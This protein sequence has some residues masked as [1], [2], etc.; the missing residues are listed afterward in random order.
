MS[1]NKIRIEKY[2]GASAIGSYGDRKDELCSVNSTPG[3]GFLA[4]VCKDWEKAHS[5]VPAIHS[6]IVR[7]GVVLDRNSGALK[8]M[9]QTLPYF[10]ACPGSGMQ[11]LSWIHINDLSRIFLH[12]LQSESMIP[13]I[14]G[15]SP[16]PSSMKEFTETLKQIYKPFAGVIPAPSIALQT[17]LG[18]MSQIVLHSQN[19][20][21]RELL[22]NKFTFT[23][24]TLFEALK[25]ISGHIS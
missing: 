9:L 22:E 23:Y 7:I 17:I 6:S 13:I 3:D 14:N 4:K 15:V 8:E 24:P 12:Q 5:S 25:Q 21:N 1:K 10:I 2:I 20:S 16:S 11:I 19:C 18:E